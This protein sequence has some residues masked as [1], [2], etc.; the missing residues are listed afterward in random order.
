MNKLCTTTLD[1]AS[2]IILS[3]LDT[4]EDSRF[5]AVEGGGD[6]N[7]FTISSV[8][9]NALR[10]EQAQFVKPYYYESGAVIYATPDNAH[11]EGIGQ[12]AAGE[13]CIGF[14]YNSNSFVGSSLVPVPGL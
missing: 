2:P 5:T 8:S 1:C 11:A 12:V 9:V 3:D 7:P 13:N 4:P 6:A 14:L 10:A